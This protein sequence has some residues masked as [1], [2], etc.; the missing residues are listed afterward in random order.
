VNSTKPPSYAALP[1]YIAEAAGAQFMTRLYAAAER[2]QWVDER[3]AAAFADGPEFSG[4][5]D[6]EP[7]DI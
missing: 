2:A 5:Q 1:A 6:V 3:V 7:E 4:G